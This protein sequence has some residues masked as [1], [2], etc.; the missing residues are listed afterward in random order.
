MADADAAKRFDNR[1]YSLL[2][3]P[4]LNW[5]HLDKSPVTGFGEERWQWEAVNED[6]VQVQSKT[7]NIG[8]LSPCIFKPR[9]Y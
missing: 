2:V 4:S 7:S 1:Y 9:L 8:F 5:T 6:D 3:D